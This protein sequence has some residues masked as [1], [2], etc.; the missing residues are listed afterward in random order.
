MENSIK[1]EANTAATLS[2]I[3]PEIDKLR[4]KSY[5]SSFMLIIVLVLSASVAS[6]SAY[7]FFVQ[8][9][10]LDL[11]KSDLG[12]SKA[13]LND[14]FIHVEQSRKL[15]AQQ[16][17]DRKSIERAIS[18]IDNSA[19]KMDR[20]SHLIERASWNIP[21]N[22]KN[23]VTSSI[24]HVV[25]GSF[26]GNM[27]GRENAIKFASSL[28]NSS[29]PQVWLTPARDY[30]AVT[31]GKPVNQRAAADLARSARLS[32]KHLDAY[33]QYERPGQTWEQ[34]VFDGTCR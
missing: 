26:Q 18:Y 8:K 23:T 15:L 25:I 10:N 29:C 28:D 27:I 20:A 16:N 21:G 5:I 7:D 31:I 11:A 22:S 19:Y 3:I 17:V 32:G 4:R 30:Y 24:W 1:N 33:A 9:Q 2:E 34:Q 12:K 14:A 6:T 13:A